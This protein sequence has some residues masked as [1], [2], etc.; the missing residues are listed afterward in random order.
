VAPLITVGVDRNP[1]P[2]DLY[3]SGHRI[4]II[5][6]LPRLG[7]SWSLQYFIAMVLWLPQTQTKL[8]RSPPSIFHRHRQ[9]SQA[10]RL[11]LHGG[12]Y[13]DWNNRDRSV[14]RQRRCCERRR[15]NTVPCHSGMA[16]QRQAR[17][18]FFRRVMDS[19]M[20]NCTS[21]L[22]TSSRPGMTEQSTLPPHGHGRTSSR[23]STSLSPEKESKTWMPATS[24]GMTVGDDFPERESKTRI[25]GT[26]SKPDQLGRH[27]AWS[28]SY[29]GYRADRREL[30]LAPVTA[31]RR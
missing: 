21:R 1:I 20:C 8:Y 23:P 3:L 24:A 4:I 19:L 26:S 30:S 11:L 10:M 22:A 25:T 5:N 7:N 2:T 18:P 14:K 29:R 9:C 28:Q 27:Y 6:I 12:N 31:A 15:S 17:N 13:S 16:R